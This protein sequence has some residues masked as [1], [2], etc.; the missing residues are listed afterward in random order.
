MPLLGISP[1]GEHGN[2]LLPGES[3][4]IEEPG[5]L[6]SLGLQRV[7]HNWAKKHKHSTIIRGR[8][9]NLYHLS[10]CA[11]F[12]LPGWWWGRRMVLQGSVL[13]LKLLS[14]TWVGAWVPAEELKDTATYILRGGGTRTLPHSSLFAIPPFS[15]HSLSSLTSN[16]LNLPF[17]TQGRSRRLSE[18]YFLPTRNG[19]HRKDL[20]PRAPHR[21]LLCFNIPAS[22]FWYFSLL[23]RTGIR[24]EREWCFGQTG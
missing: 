15:Q 11:D 13:S 1:G 9:Q 5:R 2:L 19:G 6:Q 17:R 20:S 22:L 8:R 16:S 4:W 24:K 7:R 21:V 14:S 12:L 18:A 10:L 23:K 3:L